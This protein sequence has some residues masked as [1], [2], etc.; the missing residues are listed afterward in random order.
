MS[1]LL[2]W[3]PKSKVPRI[4]WLDYVLHNKLVAYAESEDMTVHAAI[5]FAIERLLEEINN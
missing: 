5:A 4:F 3:E 1:E 2:P